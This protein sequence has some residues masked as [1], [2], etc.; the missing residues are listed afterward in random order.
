MPSF[1]QTYRE[2]ARRNS[3]PK[4]DA[5]QYQIDNKPQAF[6]NAAQNFQ[7]VAFAKLMCKLMSFIGFLLF[8]AGLVI[9][10]YLTSQTNDY[11]SDF[12][13]RHDLAYIG[14]P[15]ISSAFTFGLPFAAVGAYMSAR[16][17][18]TQD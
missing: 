2:V 3:Q 5:I 15:L 8:A 14:L 9:G 10:I 18:G 4:R 11:G 16:L 6:R 17:R 13:D 1:F 7:S 12:F